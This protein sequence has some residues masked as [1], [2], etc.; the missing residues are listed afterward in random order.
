MG[1]E[2]DCDVLWERST[3]QRSKDAIGTV[4]LLSAAEA[5]VVAAREAPL[6]R[7]QLI[8]LLAVAA[9]YAAHDFDWVLPKVQQRGDS[10]ITT[11]AKQLGIGTNSEPVIDAA[12]FR[13]MCTAR[14]QPYFARPAA[15]KQAFTLAGETRL[16]DT[17]AARQW[18]EYPQCIAAFVWAFQHLADSD[19]GESISSI[20]PVIITLVD[21][22]DCQAQLWGLRLAQSLVVRG[23]SV[24]LRKSGICKVISDSAAKCLT[25]RSDA[26]EFASTLMEAA[27]R[28]AIAA[29]DVL[30]PSSADPRYTSQLWKLVSQVIT[31]DVYIADNVVAATVLCAQVTPL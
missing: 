17:I 23:D 11:I 24:F 25:Y 10:W 15:P 30:Y 7:A 21:D 1:Y 22:Y 14:V 4:E 5:A 8:A 20:L 12:I 9:S 29:C 13:E 6:P 3:Q 27:F 31:N 28:T 16:P 26:N 18:M 2:E 19:I